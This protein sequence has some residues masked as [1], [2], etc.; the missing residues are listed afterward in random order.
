[1]IF[2]T[3][4][5]IVTYSRGEYDSCKFETILRDNK[6]SIIDISDLINE[7]IPEVKFLCKMLAQGIDS[8][9]M[10]EVR[11]KRGLT[12]GIGC[13]TAGPH[14]SSA[15]YVMGST[16]K[17]KVEEFRD[18]VDYVFNNKDKFMTKERFN[19]IMESCRI[20]KIKREILRYNNYS[21]YI[22]SPIKSLSLNL[23]KITYDGVIEVYD[24]YFNIETFKRTLDTDEY[25]NA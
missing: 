25:I 21:E 9:L 3:P 15:I 11:T 19:I 17:D 7:R 20:R 5:N 16:S 12:Y 22:E 13:N 10:D 6:S 8:P 4:D 14:D 2:S 1:M 24:K 18:A 23:D